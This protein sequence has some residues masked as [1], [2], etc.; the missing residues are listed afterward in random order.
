[1]LSDNHD[2]AHDFPEHKEKIHNLKINDTH[3]AKLFDEYD[4]VNKEILRI[5]KEIEA[6]SDERLEILKKKRLS[7]SDQMIDIIQKVS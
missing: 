2:L 6:S 3:F 5:E 1:M 4:E 7:L